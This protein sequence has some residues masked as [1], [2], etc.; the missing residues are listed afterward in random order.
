MG[1][2][3]PQGKKRRHDTKKCTRRS[4]IVYKCIVIEKILEEKLMW[5]PKS[6][7]S[8]SILVNGYVLKVI[9]LKSFMP[10]RIY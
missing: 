7:I 4:M 1:L 3:G 5:S 2:N 6:I 10:V 8:I 9:S